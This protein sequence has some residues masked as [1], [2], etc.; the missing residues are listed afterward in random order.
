MVEKTIFLNAM[1]VD[2]EPENR[3]RIKQAAGA[4]AKFQEVT[5]AR[6]LLKAK[7]L[8]T[9]EKTYDIF[10][11]AERFPEEALQGFIKEAKGIPQS[12]DAAFI[13]LTR[14][15]ADAG[16]KAARNLLA[17][18]DG[19]LMEPYSVDVVLEITELAERVKLERREAREKVVINVLLKE[20]M[21]HIDRIAYIK[22]CRVNI[23]TVLERL[24]EKN[25]AFSSL[26]EES[27]VIYFQVAM[28]LFL[29]EDPGAF[30]KDRKNYQ[31]TSERIKVKMA[32]K[33]LAEEVRKMEKS[34]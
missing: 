11:L 34:N 22:S 12:Q 17:G 4:V 23:S 16:V 15:S 21:E 28:E 25:Q 20:L 26:D 6:D 8:I 29:S 14:P 9:G 1:A 30:L 31:G 33:L 32:E 27:L 2:T 10:F 5:L 7:S 3:M 18:F 24:K 19:F 13:L